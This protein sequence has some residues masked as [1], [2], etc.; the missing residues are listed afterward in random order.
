MVWIAA[1]ALDPTYQEVLNA[2][3]SG[4]LSADQVLDSFVTKDIRGEAAVRRA[5]D[6]LVANGY[7]DRDYPDSRAPAVYALPANG[8]T[9]NGLLLG[10]RVKDALRQWELSLQDGK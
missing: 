6:V 9:G 1:M 10:Q 8:T 4:P 2:L 5:L 7:L 3:S